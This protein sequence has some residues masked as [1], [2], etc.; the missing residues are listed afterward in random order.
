[1]RFFHGLVAATLAACFSSATFAGAFGVSPIRVD[2]DAAV[3]TGLVT[4]SNDDDRKL[5]FQVKLFEWT[6]NAAGEDEYAENSDLLFFPQV[7]TVDPR[8]KRIV[9]IGIK[10]P[11]QERE[12][13]FRLFIEEMPDR[14]AA[15]VAG[16][17]VAVRLRFGVPVFLSSGKGE[18]RPEII[19]AE[20][21]KGEVR[22]AIRNDGTRQVRFEEITVRA[23]EKA[24]AK[25]AGWYVFPGATRLF[26]LPVAAQDCPIPAA[27]EIHATA[28]G[29]DIRRT[30]EVP[31]TL[32]SP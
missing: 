27:V 2:L 26:T 14:G 5:N 23:G 17:Q 7:F 32:C 3:R 6:Q 4:V 18:A 25:T 22:V 19:S 15:P 13:A 21:F 24:I 28:D 9:R 29:K 16:A 12:R 10:A 11:P 1:M 31:A 20:A 8:D 30:L